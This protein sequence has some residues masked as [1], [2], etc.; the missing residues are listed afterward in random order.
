M[1]GA[2]YVLLRLTTCEYRFRYLLISEVSVLD[3]VW[4]LQSIVTD[5]HIVIDANQPHESDGGIF[6]VVYR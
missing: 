6:F 4:D 1:P 2:V 5:Y 3:G